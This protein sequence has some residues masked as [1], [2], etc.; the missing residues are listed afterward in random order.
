MQKSCSYRRD[1]KIRSFTPAENSPMQLQLVAKITLE[2]TER[3]LNF[4]VFQKNDSRQTSEIEES[5]QNA[6]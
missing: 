3:Q 1:T 6:L 5:R 4:A 2:M